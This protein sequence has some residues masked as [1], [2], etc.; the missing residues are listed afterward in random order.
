[1]FGYVRPLKSELL[2]REFSRYRAVYCGICHSISSEYGQLP[3]LGTSYD[4]T[5]LALLLLALQKEEANLAKTGCILSPLQKRPYIAG[6]QVMSFCAAL[7]VLLAWHKAQDQIRDK[8]PLGGHA[9]R[10]AF[11]RAK[12][13]AAGKYPELAAI[14]AAGLQEQVELEKTEPSPEA[15][16]VFARTLEQVFDLAA[17][18]VYP[19]GRLRQALARL[20]FDLGRWIYLLD[21]IDD[22]QDDCDNNN[23][24]PFAGHDLA[25]AKAEAEIL[26]RQ[27]EEALD[28]TA[29]LL[30]Y[31]RDSG[32]MA[33][34]FTLGLPFVREQV[35]AGRPLEKL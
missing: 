4:L 9:A 24:N 1:M 25:G 21:A 5:F 3:R 18:L 17:G 30:P 20:G 14:L 2:L 23:W 12:K 28:R 15:A 33:N 32:I 22:W 26:L 35:L 19:K 7:T 27:A 29:A 13:R 31:E 10:L 6:G 8:K 16:V 11:G 34:L